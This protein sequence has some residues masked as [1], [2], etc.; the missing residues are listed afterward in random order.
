MST[1]TVNQPK[2]QRKMHEVKDAELFQFTRLGQTLEGVLVSIE[3]VTLKGQAGKL[4][5]FFEQPEN[6][7][8]MSCLGVTDLN[9]K[10]QPGYLG[11]W[12]EIRY[13]SDLKLPNQPAENSDMKIFNVSVAE[14]IERGYEH[15]QAA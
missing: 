5:Y 2:L 12:I 15:L 4:K 9:K 6:K 7:T 13:E 11:Y 1:S 14:T 10:I 8:R 3:P